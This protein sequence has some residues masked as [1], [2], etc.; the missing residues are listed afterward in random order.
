MALVVTLWAGCATSVS[1]SSSVAPVSSAPAVSSVASADPP[2][3]IA[4]ISSSIKPACEKLKIEIPPVITADIDVPVPPIVDASGKSL[5]PFYE[6]LAKL[7]R[8]KATEPVRI[9]FHGDSNMTLDMMSGW[10]RRTLQKQ[11]GDGGHGFVALGNPWTHYKHRDVKHGL[12]SRIGWK[13]YALSTHKIRDGFYGVGGLAVESMQ[14]KAGSFVATADPPALVGQKVN[15]FDIHYLKRP[16]YGAF[17]VVLDGTKVTRVTTD[18]PTASLGVHRMD[19]PD[20]PHRLEMIS[21]EQRPVRL[22]GVALERTSPGIIVD[23]LGIGG[24]SAD[25]LANADSNV[26]IESLHE[27]RYDLVMFLL[28]SNT[29]SFN[30]QPRN[31]KKLI[32]MHREALPGASLLIMSPPDHAESVNSGGSDPLTVRVVKQNREIAADNNVAFWDFWEAMGGN[33]AMLKFQKKKWNLWDLYH[34]NET[35]AEYM[36]SRIVH[37]LWRDWAAYLD[38]HPDAGCN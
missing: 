11:L 24:S 15:H 18:S 19:V 16:G 34:L 32:T 25:A 29:A 35:G 14:P 22:F 20:G 27:R 36:A 33:G 4:P 23:S 1:P 12:A 21:A 38:T 10:I 37:A 31:M 7:A 17:D 8:G 5:A 28:G 3:D 26:Q 6:K 2:P 9:A 13:E 30:G